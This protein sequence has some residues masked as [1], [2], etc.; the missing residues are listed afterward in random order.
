M[1]EWEFQIGRFDIRYALTYLNI[2][3]AA[4]QEGHLTRLVKIFS[5]LQSVPGKRKSNV[6]SPEDIGEINGKVCNTKYWLEKYPRAT[7]EIGEGLLEPRE[8]SLSTTVYF[9]S[10]H[11]HDQVTCRS[12]SVVL[13]FIG[14]TPIS[15]TSK[16]QGTIESSSCSA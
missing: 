3:Y 12:V 4:P 7:E 16:R 1:E 9:D 2:F 10:D 8:L 15:L 14:S 13:S 5:N 6:V 11:A